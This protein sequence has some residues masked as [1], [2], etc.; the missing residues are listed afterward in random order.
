VKIA[1]EK[2][3]KFQNIIFFPQPSTNLQP[4]DLN[5]IAPKC[6]NEWKNLDFAV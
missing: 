3:Q 1:A 2:S 5:A 4:T 6:K